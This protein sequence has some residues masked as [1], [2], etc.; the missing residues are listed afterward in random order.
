MGLSDDLLASC[1]ASYDRTMAI[2]G[3]GLETAN[4]YYTQHQ[5]EVEIRIGAKEQ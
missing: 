4:A 3:E 5:T 2:V 1:Q